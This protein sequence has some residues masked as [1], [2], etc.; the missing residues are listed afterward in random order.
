MNNQQ[1]KRGPGAPRGNMNALK[2]GRSSRQFQLV[3]AA[4]LDH[5]ELSQ[6]EGGPALLVRLLPA[7]IRADKAACRQAEERARQMLAPYQEE[8]FIERLAHRLLLAII[9][10]QQR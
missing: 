4:L 2:G 10:D 3:A 9:E 5:P 8:R 1:P 6:A 7:V